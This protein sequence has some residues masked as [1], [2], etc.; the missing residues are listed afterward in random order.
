[1]F[2]SK[3]P[4]KWQY[5]YNFAENYLLLSQ[6]VKINDLLDTVRFCNEFEEHFRY[7]PFSLTSRIFGGR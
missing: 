4:I 2:I 7:H 1:M 3:M 5:K 6:I